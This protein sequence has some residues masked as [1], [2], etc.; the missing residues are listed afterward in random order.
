MP[1]ITKMPLKV[2]SATDIAHQCHQEHLK[3]RRECV[4]AVKRQHPKSQTIFDERLSDMTNE[5]GD[6]GSETCNQKGISAFEVDGY[7]CS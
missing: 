3:L 7:A 4:P 2:L 6:P 1:F 5:M